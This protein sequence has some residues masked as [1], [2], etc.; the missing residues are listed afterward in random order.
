MTT[1]RVCRGLVEEPR[2]V[3]CGEACARVMRLAE[4]ELSPRDRLR[5]R[6]VALRARAAGILLRSPARKPTAIDDGEPRVPHELAAEIAAVEAWIETAPRELVTSTH[7]RRSARTA[8][9]LALL[10]AAAALLLSGCARAVVL[11]HVAGVAIL[12]ALF[13]AASA[14]GHAVR[15]LDERARRGR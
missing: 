2:T 13:V 7:A 10:A 1:C 12:G 15:R 8:T 9:Q 14:I 11:G 4:A 3:Y 6:L 5:R